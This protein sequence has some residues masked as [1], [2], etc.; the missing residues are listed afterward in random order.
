[1]PTVN[2]RDE[3]LPPAPRSSG[4]IIHALES[5]LLPEETPGV[6]IGNYKLLQKIG[7]GGFG[8]VWMAE[9]QEPVRRR[10][11]I[12]VIK[13][14]MDTAEVIARFE[15]ERQ[16]LALMEHP[17]IARVF[18]AG[19]TDAGRPYFVMELVRGVPITRY[20]DEN[21]LPAEARLHL[22]MSVCQAVQHAHQ[23]GVIHRDLKPS[24]I[25][26]TLHDG[27]PV[28]KIID[29]GIAKATGGARLTDK[30]LFT[31]FYAFIGTPA[32]TSPEQIE[33]S[34]LDVDTRS[35]IYSLG[36]LLYEL[37]AG[38]QPFDSD[39]LVK[40]G[41][42][43]MR[44]T[45]RE[46]DPPRPSHRL[47][48]LT[49][50]E[51]T[52]V[53][54]HRSTDAGKLS[55]LLRGDLDLIVMHCLEKSRT[56]RYETANGLLMDI[57]RYLASEPVVAR[58]PTQT[59]RLRKFVRR[60]KLAVTAAA[61]VAASLVAGLVA[62]SVLLLRERTAHA[63]AVVAEQAESRLRHEADQ[64]REFETK[65][66]SRTAL[67][68][69]GQLLEKGQTAD[70]LAY[71][72]Y[73]AQKDPGNALIAPRLASVLTSHNFLIPEGA[74]FQ[75][76]SRVLA[77]HYTADGRS[78][79]AGTEDGTFR[80]ID[81]ASG[82]LKREVRLGKKVRRGGWAF[83]DKD[84]PVFAVSFADQTIGLFE[85]KSG[86]PVWPLIQL[87]EELLVGSGVRFSP[88]ARW[89][90]ANGNGLNCFW[91]WDAATGK[92]LI[93]QSFAPHY[94][95][96]PDISKD[97]TRL[98][99]VYEDKVNVWSLPECKPSFEPVPIKRTFV[100]DVELSP[101]FS[102]DG[103]ILAIVD[104]QE[105]VQLFDPT[106]G[107]SLQP[108]IRGEFNTRHCTGF[109]PDG[110]LF[111]PNAGS[112][113]LLDVAT[114]IA[115]SL[116]V[117]PGFS[118]GGQAFSADGKFIVTAS[119]DGFPRLW[120]TTTG[121]LVAEATLQQH[122][123]FC[124]AP[125]PD[126]TQ[127]ALGTGGG[128]ILRLRVGR[129]AA[130]PLALHPYH[131]PDIHGPPLF[132]EGSTR[133]LWFQED[134]AVVLDVASGHEVAGGFAY[135]PSFLPE[136][137]IPLTVG[138]SRSDRKFFVI[139]DWS[140]HR[141]S[142]VWENT[143][144]GVRRV[145][146]LQ[147]D[148][149][150]VP[151]FGYYRSVFSAEGDLFARK[152]KGLGEIG[153]W[154]L[155]TGARVGP[156]CSYQDKH[157]SA[158]QCIDFSPDGKRLAAGTEEG[159]VVVWDVATGQVITVLPMQPDTP[160]TNVQ[161]SPD[162][163]RLLTV[164]G[165]NQARLWNAATGEPCSALLNGAYGPKTGFSP[166][167][168]WL[169]TC[170]DPGLKIW[171]GKNGTLVSEPSRK[172]GLNAL[173]SRNGERI[174]I[175]E[176]DNLQVYDVR[177]G[178]PF[179]ESTRLHEPYLADWSPDGRFLELGA[180]ND[181]GIGEIHFLSVPPPLPEGTPIPPWLLQL[182]SICGAKKVNEA[183]QCVD[184]PEVVAQIG[185]VRRQLAALPNDAP[186]VEWGR[187]F[188]DD[189]PTRSIAPGFTITPAEADKLEAEGDQPTTQ[190]EH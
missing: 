147:G 166:D 9:Q 171:D 58:P 90:Y 45:I 49:D 81:A 133:L 67:D 186:Y 51:R 63:H 11:A 119:D 1:M 93:K 34:G 184:A 172:P 178:Q 142:V 36:V 72:V 144:A 23:K 168:R 19:A 148:S 37:L 64:A 117:A 121:W 28:P 40:S 50:E 38:R 158:F 175:T 25:L 24:N 156:G 137:Q 122:D 114:G 48:T 80:M 89:L 15:A 88:D 135:P 162:G 176:G 62:S 31:Q 150:A 5:A 185:D 143:G 174:A 46:I 87:D 167:G 79:Y 71:L 70:A 97:G 14:G 103:R 73:A 21:R 132:E 179:T 130:R 182:A 154:N 161:F 77:V 129:G 74:P 183:G 52:T 151:G 41:L 139:Q 127:V 136:L 102:P 173:F 128:A 44:R 53:A 76:G 120:E 20:C 59:Y 188:L 4:E 83:V 85:V 26:V 115:T 118:N 84:E 29:F 75:C 55:L 32:Y 146:I 35:D 106:N 141:P 69:A 165:Q 91:V 164:S 3:K 108:T 78:I 101:Q 10:V 100:P 140:G 99:F 54:Q 153:V 8:V 43:A 155:H 66:S 92:Q 134:H 17:N 61:A 68:L 98:A 30:T 160:C 56:R 125:S 181:R 7:E 111:A 13:P 177:A 131:A 187:W 157:I 152:N 107:D 18:D 16:A 105:G 112:W 94:C 2:S 22:F 123:T 109:F 33:M 110:R 116:P 170:D 180:K 12:K 6:R 113:D 104:G 126:G 169:L 96:G 124:A 82:E 163:T 149:G 189:S 65:R 27:V 47:I 42:E 86:R 190:N 138:E 57:R 95:W 159:K 60:H 145:G 39:A